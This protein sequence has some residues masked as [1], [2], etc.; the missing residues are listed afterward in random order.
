VLNTKDLALPRT[1]VVKALNTS[2]GAFR[3]R[4]T[5]AFRGGAAV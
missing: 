2:L 5:I 3:G 1:S 4:D